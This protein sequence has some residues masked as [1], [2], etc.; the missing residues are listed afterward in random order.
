MIVYLHGFNSGHDPH[1]VK[2]TALRKLDKEVLGF[3]YD[4]FSPR[5]EVIQSIV[6]RIKEYADDLLIVGTSLG[7]YYADACAKALGVPCVLINPCVDPYNAFSDRSLETEY[8]NYVHKTVSRLTSETV[9]SWKGHSMT[10]TVGHTYIP[11][12]LLADGD[13]VFDS[14]ET[15]ETLRN[16]EVMRFL[17]GTHRFEQI[18]DSVKSIEIYRNMCKIAANLNF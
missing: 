14:S 18:E 1:N 17:G 4:T 9:E 15:A 2:I 7:A 16:Y 5:E 10:E 12:V 3:S 8:V 6:D 11:L 13:E